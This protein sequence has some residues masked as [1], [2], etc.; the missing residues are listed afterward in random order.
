MKVKFAL[1]YLFLVYS[2]N[3][4]AQNRPLATYTIRSKN[5]DDIDVAMKNIIAGKLVEI[6]QRRWAE[7][8]QSIAAKSGGIVINKEFFEK[9]N[10]EIDGRGR[11]LFILF[12]KVSTTFYAIQIMNCVNTSPSSKLR[13]GCELGITNVVF[14]DGRTDYTVKSKNEV[15][16]ALRRFKKDILPRLKSLMH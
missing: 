3:G 9:N 2:F 16:A 11:S 12:D 8:E 6:N 10:Y 14:D 5:Y 7:I 15:D 4:H 1:L 13:W